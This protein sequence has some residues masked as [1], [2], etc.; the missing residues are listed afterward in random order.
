MYVPWSS[1]IGLV[2]VPAVPMAAVSV[3][4]LKKLAPGFVLLRQCLAY[5]QPRG[6]RWDESIPLVLK[7]NHIQFIS[8][9]FLLY[10]YLIVL[11]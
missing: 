8:Y 5:M 11:C 1:L 4:L 10:E 6:R 7:V 3:E 2:E 9:P